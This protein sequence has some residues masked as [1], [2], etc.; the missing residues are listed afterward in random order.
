MKV[1][2]T[3]LIEKIKKLEKIFHEV[4]R[5][6]LLMEKK[7]EEQNNN[8]RQRNKKIQEVQ[9]YLIIPRPNLWAIS[10]WLLT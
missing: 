4:D 10:N 3:T 7:N 6:V 1:E 9:E 2:T 8:L 5:F